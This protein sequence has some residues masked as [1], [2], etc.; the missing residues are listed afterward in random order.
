MKI[1]IIVLNLI[2]FNIIEL[3]IVVF[4]IYIIR[5]LL[6]L[7]INIWLGSFVDCLNKKCF[8]IVLGLFFIW[9]FLLLI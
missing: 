5:V 6:I 9:V 7:F 1:Y 4:Y 2:V 3:V 8:M